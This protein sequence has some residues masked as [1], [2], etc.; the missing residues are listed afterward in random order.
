MKQKENY[1][2]QILMW[3][4]PPNHNVILKGKALLRNMTFS[5]EGMTYMGRRITGI[6]S[7]EDIF[8]LL[9][10]KYLPP[11]KRGK[12]YEGYKKST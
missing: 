12:K 2:C 7:E 1:Y 11:N 4:G 3:T 9:E 8:I 5:S 6:N 10:K